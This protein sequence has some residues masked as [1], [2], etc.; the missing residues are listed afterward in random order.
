MKDI[1]FCDKT[2]TESKVEIE[3]TK[4]SENHSRE[5]QVENKFQ[6]KDERSL[7]KTTQTKKVQSSIIWTKTSLTVFIKRQS[8]HLRRSNC[9][10]KTNFVRRSCDERQQ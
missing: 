10:K 1:K 7:L 3:N 2:I 4:K 5:Q 9:R 6:S 8:V